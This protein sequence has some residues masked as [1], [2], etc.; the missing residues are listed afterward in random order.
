MI[1]MRLMALLF[2]VAF[3]GF[4]ADAVLTNQQPLPAVAD[5]TALAAAPQA[6]PV[7]QPAPPLGDRE[8]EL[9]VQQ[10]N[11]VKAFSDMMLK[12]VLWA[13]GTVV[14]IALGLVAYNWWTSHK[15]FERD[16]QRLKEETL[17]E[18]DK[19][20]VGLSSDL[21]K[22]LRDA[23][24]SSDDKALRFKQELSAQA[25]T[26]SATL[27]RRTIQFADDITKR[28]ETHRRE[29]ED[30]LR[31]VT[32]TQLPE[33]EARLNAAVVKGDAH[34]TSD[35]T[36]AVQEASLKAA[37][38]RCVVFHNMAEER[39]KMQHWSTA[40]HWYFAAFYAGLD[41]N[42]NYWINAALLGLE[43]A[44][45]NGGLTDKDLRTKFEASE[46]RVPEPAK[47]PFR[48]VKQ[49]LKISEAPAGQK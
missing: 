5:Q 6:A 26:L 41:A 10:I 3:S 31:N 13:L 17:N 21:E 29:I 40:I 33:L 27:E 16:R 28:L 7:P 15:M 32:N 35:L 38:V 1:V 36:K 20:I 49:V 46:K 34:V 8:R 39:A 23:I 4:A 24:T 30:A 45:Q 12:V 47:E 42:N 14:T 25:T 19:K 2:M 11:T 18:V 48:R 44:S 43:K 37:I 22:R 9:L